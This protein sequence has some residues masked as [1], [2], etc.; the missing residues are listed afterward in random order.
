MTGEAMFN[1]VFLDD[2]FVPDDCVV[3]EVG[4]GWKV[5]RNTLSNERVSLS[6]RA[7]AAPDVG[8]RTC[9]AWP[10]GSAGSYRRRSVRSWR[11]WSAR[12]RRSALLGLRVTLKQLDRGTSRAPTPSVRKLLSACARPARRGVRGRAARAPPP[13][14]AADMKLGDAGYWDRAVLVHPRD[15]DLR[16]HH[17]G[18]AQ[19]H[20]RAHAGPAPRPR[21]GQVAGSARSASTEVRPDGRGLALPDFGQGEAALF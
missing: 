6:L 2:V 10:D 13:L 7:R 12:G 19:H 8:L 14:V 17:G 4:Q 16:R 15:D 21:A 9:S 5:A 20:R 3:G 11:G 1:E 18:P